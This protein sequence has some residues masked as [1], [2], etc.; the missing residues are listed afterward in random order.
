M[1][2]TAINW[3]KMVWDLDRCGYDEHRVA[4]LI[5]CGRTTVLG[6]RDRGSEPLYT[7]GERLIR[8]WRD[9]T[10]SYTQAVPRL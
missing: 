3:S 10:N 8:L 5:N 7:R 2:D 4:R 9:K 6:W 1:E